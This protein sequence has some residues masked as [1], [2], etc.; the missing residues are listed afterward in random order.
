[1]ENT[2]RG[3]KATF[4]IGKGKKQT[5]KFKSLSELSKMVDELVDKHWPV[6]PLMTQIF[7]K[8]GKR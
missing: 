1:M 5:F 6:L 4:K 3:G 7:Y 2:Q 8:D